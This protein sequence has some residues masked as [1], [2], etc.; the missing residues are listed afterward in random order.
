MCTIP[1]ALYPFF[2]VHRY[3]YCCSNYYYLDMTFSPHAYC[4][5]TVNVN[6]NENRFLKFLKIGI[7]IL[8]LL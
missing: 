5:I 8:G 6:L 4:S 2:S 7:P 3:M 1:K